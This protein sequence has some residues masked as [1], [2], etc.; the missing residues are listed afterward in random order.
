ML[1]GFQ[2]Q[3]GSIN[4]GLI[5]GKPKTPSL[6]GIR[7]QLDKLG[8]GQ[9]RTPIQPDTRNERLGQAGQQAVRLGTVFVQHRHRHDVGIGE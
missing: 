7:R 4:G 2:S 8:T 3:T 6:E 1:A 9:R 5:G